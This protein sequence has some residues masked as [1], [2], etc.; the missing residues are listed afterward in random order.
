MCM[1]GSLLQS[2]KLLRILHQENQNLLPTSSNGV[3]SATGF[4]DR[5][6]SR[7]LG[8]KSFKCEHNMPSNVRP[9]TKSHSG[10]SILMRERGILSQG[11]KRRTSTKQHYLFFSLSLSGYSPA[12]WKWTNDYLS[13]LLE[14]TKG[15]LHSQFEDASGQL[16]EEVETLVKV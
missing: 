10:K 13:Y 14:N 7:Q 9:E 11:A 15:V 2:I 3:N 16:P 12:A 1:I 4:S 6:P 8:R 5:V